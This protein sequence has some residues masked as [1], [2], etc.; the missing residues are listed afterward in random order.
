MWCIVVRGCDTL[1]EGVRSCGIFFQ[2]LELSWMSV[3]VFVLCRTFTGDDFGRR[4]SRGTE[5][6]GGDEIPAVS[7][8]QAEVFRR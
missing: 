5:C 3:A 7:N 6:L 8:P 1:D 2:I 4:R